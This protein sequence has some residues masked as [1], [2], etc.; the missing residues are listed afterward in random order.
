MQR[1]DQASRELGQW[2]YDFKGTNSIELGTNEIT[3]HRASSEDRLT[4][5]AAPLEEKRWSSAR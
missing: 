5:H 1:N 3:L 2:W 4:V